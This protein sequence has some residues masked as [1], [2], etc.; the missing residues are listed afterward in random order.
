MGLLDQVS[1]A[2]S[3]LLCGRPAANDSAESHFFQTHKWC[4]LFRKLGCLGKMLFQLIQKLNCVEIKWLVLIYLLASYMNLNHLNLRQRFCKMNIYWPEFL[5]LSPS[6]CF[7]FSPMDI[8]EQDWKALHGAIFLC[9]TGAI[10]LVKNRNCASWVI[11]A[12]LPSVMDFVLVTTW[13]LT[14]NCNSL[15]RS[16]SDLLNLRFDVRHSSFAQGKTLHSSS[17]AW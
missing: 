8:L 10:G 2:I 4:L 15:A 3:I 11:N 9:K 1:Q 16:D 6:F 5:S 12:P 14:S 7:P 13:K 17:P